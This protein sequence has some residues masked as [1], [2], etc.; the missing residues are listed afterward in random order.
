MNPFRLVYLFLLCIA[1]QQQ[2][3]S[4]AYT[5]WSIGNPADT[6]TNPTP[7]TLLMGGATEDDQAMT[8]FLQY[9]D[10]GDVVVIR[11]SGSDGYNTYLYSDLGVQVHSVQTLLVPSIA[12]ANDSFVVQTV[13]KA[14]AL[15]IAGGDQWTYVSNWKNTPLNDAINYLVNVRKVPIGGTSAGMAVMG[16]YYNSAQG[17]SAISAT[18][19]ANPY[20]ATVTIGNSDFIDNNIMKKIITDT[21]FDNPD[22]RGRLMTFLARTWQD[23][24]IPISAI[25]CD[26]YTAV[27]IDTNQKATVYGGK[28]SFDDNAYFVRV[29]CAGNNTIEN[30]SS[31]SALQWKRD[32]TV[33]KVYRIQSD[34]SGTQFFDLRNFGPSPV[35]NNQGGSWLD[36]WVDNGSFA[37][38]TGIAPNC[39]PSLLNNS[40]SVK[41]G[42]RVAPNPFHSGFELLTEF[43]EAE[44]L[45]VSLCDMTGR[46]RY[47][48]DEPFLCPVGNNRVAIPVALDLR[49][50]HYI[51]EVVTRSGKTYRQLVVRD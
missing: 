22:R 40:V 12:A 4:Q 28:P 16:E 38:K 37:G 30:C 43:D 10:H 26:E 32:S 47:V 29:D 14:E 6:V 15:W 1:I 41:T 33:V 44:E 21:H 11:T 8:R 20:D 48:S 42:I 27:F 18:V 5:L 36:W 45:R 34:S 23:K 39:A 35:F 17:G 7:C 46:I 2:G 3:I 13:R 19:L 50:G 24:G 49:S 31:G 25:A 9:A 51:L